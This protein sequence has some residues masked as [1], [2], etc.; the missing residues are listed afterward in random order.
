MPNVAYRE[1]QHAAKE[2]LAPAAFA[3]LVGGPVGGSPSRRFW[4]WGLQALL[5]CAPNVVGRD[6]GDQLAAPLG[7]IQADDA[8]AQLQA[9]DGAFQEQAGQGSSRDGGGGEQEEQGQAGGPTQQCMQPVAAQERARMVGRR[10]ADGRIR[11]RPP[12]GQGRGAVDAEIAAAES[13]GVVLRKAL[14]D[15]LGNVGEGIAGAAVHP[16]LLTARTKRSA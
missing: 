5:A 14:P 9:V 11:V 15:A 3:Q 6:P 8:R 7:R 12:P 10:V 2:A 1:D 16:I 4:R 13:T